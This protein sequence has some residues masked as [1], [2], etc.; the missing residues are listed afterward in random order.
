MNELTGKVRHKKFHSH[1]DKTES[2]VNEKH[3]GFIL[4]SIEKSDGCVKTNKNEDGNFNGRKKGPHVMGMVI[5]FT[6][7]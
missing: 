2:M 7:G 6:D 4:Q 1:S 5:R 3:C